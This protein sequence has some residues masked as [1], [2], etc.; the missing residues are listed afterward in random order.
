[1]EHSKLPWKASGAEIHETDYC[2]AP[3][4]VAYRANATVK[5]DMANAE[6]IVEAVNA[7]AALKAKADMLDEALVW[8]EYGREV[9]KGLIERIGLNPPSGIAIAEIGKLLAK[10]EELTKLI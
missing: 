2:V 3:V 4:A 9:A 5:Q 10:Y 6:F 7:H 1:M 8:A